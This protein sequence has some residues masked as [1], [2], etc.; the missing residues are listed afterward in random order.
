M[1]DLWWTKW[2]WGRFSPST[3]VPPANS[4]I[5]PTTAHHL[6]SGAGTIGQI[7]TDVPSGLSLTR[8]GERHVNNDER[9]T[10]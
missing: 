4:L 5:T 9:E 7:V 1:R 8:C 6:S 3:S 10:R 2:Y